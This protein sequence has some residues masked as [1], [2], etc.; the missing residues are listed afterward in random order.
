[1]ADTATDS[2]DGWGSQSASGAGGTLR[3][4]RRDRLC[5]TKRGCRPRNRF[6]ETRFF[7]F[8]IRR[9][10]CRIRRPRVR[11]DELARDSGWFPISILVVVALNQSRDCRPP[12]LSSDS[13][14]SFLAMRPQ[15]AR[16]A[17][18]RT[19]RH[20]PIRR[21][22]GCL[23]RTIMK[24]A[25]QRGRR[26]G[27]AGSCSRP[28]PQLRQSVRNRRR[29]SAT[30]RI[31]TALRRLHIPLRRCG[32]VSAWQAFRS[33]R[34]YA[35]GSVSSWRKWSTIFDLVQEGIGTARQP[36]LDGRYGILGPIRERSHHPKSARRS[37]SAC[38][39][40]VLKCQHVLS[41]L[42]LR[43]RRLTSIP[44]VCSS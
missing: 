36:L 38:M 26:L 16:A 21:D 14:T 13:R 19:V 8:D 29:R 24:R 3:A 23:L 12:P 7:R 30:L 25:R 22:P 41:A 18:R 28:N 10:S 27:R 35:A 11:V 1:M 34:V 43:S 15:H 2:K 4:S 20:D 31:A 33:Y 5:S 17:R 40:G 6:G 39:E 32:G 37:G 9:F 44:L 42:D